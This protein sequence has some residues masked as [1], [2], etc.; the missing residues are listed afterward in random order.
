MEEDLIRLLFFAVLMVFWI[1]SGI[2]KKNAQPPKQT[3]RPEISEARQKHPKPLRESADR[4]RSMPE[5]EKPAA[6]VS[7]EELEP[8]TTAEKPQKGLAEELLAMLQAQ[9]EPKPVQVEVIQ[10]VEIE[11]VVEEIEPIEVVDRE[12]HDRFHALYVEEEKPSK[13]YALDAEDGAEAYAIETEVRKPYQ[14]GERAR[15]KK[16]LSR[17]ELRHAFIMREVLGPPKAL[18]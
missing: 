18:E 13:P 5:F 10:P 16:K 11:E 17:S 3:P 15:A 2:K 1:L 8:Q 9:A 14:I 7:A 12:S 4:T 6:R